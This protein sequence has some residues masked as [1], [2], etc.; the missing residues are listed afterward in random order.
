MRYKGQALCTGGSHTLFEV[1]LFKT[2]G[3]HRGENKGNIISRSVSFEV[4]QF[5]PFSP[6]SGERFAL[7]RRVESPRLAVRPDKGAFVGGSVLKRP[8]H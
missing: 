5:S 3:D 6:A 1:A 7:P 2:A 8:P 4:A